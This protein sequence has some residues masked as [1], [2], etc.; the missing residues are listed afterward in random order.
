[1]AHFFT[2]SRTEFWLAQMLTQRMV[3][4]I[5]ND[6]LPPLLRQQIATFVSHLNH[7]VYCSA[8]HS[9]DVEILGGDPDA[10]GKA[11]ADLDAAPLDE[12]M[13]A[14]LR[15]VRGLVNDSSEF[16]E[17]DWHQA[18]DAGW[19]NDELESAIYVAAWFQ[20]MNTIATGNL[21]PATDK[22]TALALAR[23]RQKP[24]MYGELVSKLEKLI[25]KSISL[26]IEELQEK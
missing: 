2:K 10:I 25:G 3:E 16:G 8:S 4:Q 23:S 17:D 18:I 26:N 1:M 5:G 7:C 20:F 9:A 13:R 15:F 14:L 22:K 21:I 19:S 12:K 6:P 11:A 24:E